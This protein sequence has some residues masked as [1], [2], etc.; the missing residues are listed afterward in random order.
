MD[1]IHQRKMKTMNDGRKRQGSDSQN[2]S[3]GC[4]PAA[5]KP[6]SGYWVS[7]S[8]GYKGGHPVSKHPRNG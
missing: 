2:K 7:T 1:L 8:L 5:T 6:S 3:K 4:D